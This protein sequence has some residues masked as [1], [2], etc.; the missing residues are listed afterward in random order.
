VAADTR[1]R[2]LTRDWLTVYFPAKQF[3][4]FSPGALVVRTVAAP[5]ALLA[6]IRRTIQAEE[7]AA[8][9]YS[10]ETMEKMLADE[11]ARQRTAVAIATLFA[12]I[13]IIVAAIGV[14][15]VVSYEIVHRA[16][17]L[18]VHSA[19]GASPG[20]ILGITLRQSLSVAAVG[21]AIGLAAASMLTRFLRTLLFEVSPLDITT[22]ALA[23]AGLL[24]IVVLA[25][26]VPA[27]RAAR[28]NPA[29]L[30]RSE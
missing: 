6:A 18:A 16:R 12:F 21:A 8:A 4:F 28:V 2:E 27:R 24:T 15:G 29:L 22:F 17:E 3:F 25:S 19:L 30:L 20:R 26:V 13:A 5:V 9:V 7:P 1:Y 23:G 14:Y 11:T 10:V